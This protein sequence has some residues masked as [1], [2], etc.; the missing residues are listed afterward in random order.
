MSGDF[1][2]IASAQIQDTAAVVVRE[3]PEA[4]I[5][6]ARRAD[7]VW[8]LD[9]VGASYP[10]L[11][12]PFVYSGAFGPDLTTGW[13]AYVF[14]HLAAEDRAASLIDGDRVEPLRPGP[15][16]FFFELRA[17][18]R[19]GFSALDVEMLDSEGQRRRMM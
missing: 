5:V 15:D 18:E 6:S 7:G 19:P 9:Q 4:V 17:M 16:G 2:V 12:G 3:G 11:D 8:T 14:G 1:S 13:F 10:I